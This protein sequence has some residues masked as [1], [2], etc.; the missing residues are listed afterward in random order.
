MGRTSADKKVGYMYS[1]DVFETLVTRIVATPSGI[2]S[3]IQKR[4]ANDPDYSRIPLFARENFFQLRTGSERMARYCIQKK[5]VEDVTLDEIYEYMRLTGDVS[6]E[7][8]QRLKELE[9]RTE[10]D[11]SLG[12]A[13]NI[14]KVK[15]LISSGERVIL[16]SDMYLPSETIREILV[17]A[18]P[19][20]EKIPIYVS[21]EYR[22]IKST[23]N[24]FQIVKA[25][26]KVRYDEWIHIGNS[27]KGDFTA[28]GKLG[29]DARLYEYPGL[30]PAEE[31]LIRGHFDDPLIQAVVGTS[32]N[33]RTGRTLQYD[34]FSIGTAFG[35]P[36]L[37]S[38]VEWII[39]EAVVKKIKRLYFI[40]RDGFILQ[41]IADRIIRD[42]QYGI[43][44]KYI[45]GS[46]KAWRMPA[47]S[48]DDH[49]IEE[50]LN[51]SHINSL[52]AYSKLAEV[53][54]IS[55]D[56]L[57]QFIPD[58]YKKLTHFSGVMQK[59]V[60]EHLYTDDFWE[61]LVEKYAANRELTLEYLRQNIDTS[62]GNFAFVELSGSGYTQVCLAS[63]IATFYDEPIRS[64]YFKMDKM[65]KNDKCI[66]YTFYP[67]RLRQHI[68]IEVLCHAP[69]GQTVGYEI[70]GGRIDPVIETYEEE[71]LQEHGVTEYIDGI[72]AFADWRL[73]AER[74]LKGMPGVD[75]GIGY[76]E[77]LYSYMTERPDKELLDF[78]GDMP[79]SVTGREREIALYAPKLSN[80]EIRDIVLRAAGEPLEKY[81]KGTSIDCS[82]LRCSERQKKYITRLKEGKSVYAAGRRVK[83]FFRGKRAMENCFIPLELLGRRVV[84]YAA[85]K[86]GQDCNKLLTKMRGYEVV[87]WVDREWSDKQELGLKVDAPV[88][89]KDVEYD[90]VLIAIENPQIAKAVRRDLIEIGVAPEKI[91]EM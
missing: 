88:K 30:L 69:H 23:T 90:S 50:L 52:D 70:K 45:Y 34:A 71:S 44:T 72:L 85:G 65:Q 33:A 43:E 10:I 59:K 80:R 35:G 22:K 87:L 29:I 91:V 68:V 74:V 36:I 49:D 2:F 15:A 6:E 66:F 26:E 31:E 39:N 32:R 67:S 61:F 41:K 86:V 63:L 48:E 64:F 14:E 60:L 78:I 16:I 12:I 55:E 58:D 51:W 20:F 19:V 27:I 53:F 75:I 38:Y 28:P 62:D 76:I 81:Y 84:I 18:D 1:F 47:L 8:E 56:E 37:T 82:L 11:C 46:R 7:D 79:N 4:L 73:Q 3:I 54:Q 25:R 13:R 5:G 42:K 77:K 40:A 17:K 89:I 9:L 21:N 57:L 24:L 83:T